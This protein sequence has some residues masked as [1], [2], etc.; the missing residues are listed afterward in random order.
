MEKTLVKEKLIRQKL[1]HRLIIEIRGIG[2][3]L[4]LIMNNDKIANKLVLKA[5]EK[6]LIL[7]WLLIEKRGVRITPPLTISENEIEEGC[8]VI[9]DVLNSIK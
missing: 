5:K 3:M 1:S 9:L 8:N 7:F 6:G 2:L 4:C